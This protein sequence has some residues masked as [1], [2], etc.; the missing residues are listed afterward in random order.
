M[1]QG[2]LWK[3][4]F[5]IFSAAIAAADIKTGRVPRL[6]FVFAFP[7]FFV[8]KLLL[9]EHLPAWEPIVGGLTG[10]TIFLL[11]FFISGKK[12]GFADVWYSGLIGIVLGP[13]LWYAAIGS[14]CIAGLIY[15]FISKQLRIPFIPFMALGSIIVC[16]ALG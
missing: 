10:F 3:I 16:L 2:L 1:N 11:V 14:A 9:D 15:F 4:I 5:V 7:L 8:L 6:A 13:W 12:L